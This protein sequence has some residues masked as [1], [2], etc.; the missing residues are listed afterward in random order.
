MQCHILFD[1]IYITLY[2]IELMSS[3]RTICPKC[4]QKVIIPDYEPFVD[5]NELVHE[6][7]GVKETFNVDWEP[8][9]D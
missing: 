3:W 5:A 1:K 6:H 4:K 7:N 2:S 8:D 9:F